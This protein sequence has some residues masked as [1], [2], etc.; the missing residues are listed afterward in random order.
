MSVFIQFNSFSWLALA[1]SA[2]VVVST[3]VTILPIFLFEEMENIS[4]RGI[5]GETLRG[6]INL[7]IAESICIGSTLPMLSDVFLDNFSTRVKEISGRMNLMQNR[8]VFLI[9]FSV[10]SI[11]YL[12]LVDYDFLPFLYI[13]LYRT[14]C[15]VVG[16]VI[17]YAV[18]NGRIVQSWKINRIL[19]FLPVLSCGLFNICEIYSLVFPSNTLLGA[20]TSFTFALALISFIS[21]ITMWFYYLWRQYRRN[22]SLDNEEVTELVY[23]G[24][25]L[26]FVVACE[27]VDIIFGF[28]LSWYDTGGDILIG[29]AVVQV[30]VILIANVLPGRLLRNVAEV[31][32]HLKNCHNKYMILWNIVGRG[33]ASVEERV[34]TLCLS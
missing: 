34:R 29:Y 17:L 32:S 22:R 12:S 25:S 7:K 33:D 9:A 26:F 21:V 24:A 14:K 20:F 27:I 8:T 1:F 4:N 10:S 18:S 30:L 16:A 5:F 3:I 6:S 15:L 19:F 11:I 2:V 13:C 23:M 28:S 31:C